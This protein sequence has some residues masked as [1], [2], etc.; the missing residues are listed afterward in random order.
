MPSNATQKGA[1][2]PRW[3]S[4]LKYIC[5]GYFVTMWIA[6]FNLSKGVDEIISGATR[7][8]DGWAVIF[9]VIFFVVLFIIFTLADSNAAAKARTPLP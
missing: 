1:A 4:L 2:S 9:G 7:T 3:V 6:G 8:G 5:G